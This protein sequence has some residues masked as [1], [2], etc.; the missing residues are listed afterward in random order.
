[1]MF[2]FRY[3][4]LLHKNPMPFAIAKVNEQA[5]SRGKVTKNRRIQNP[6]NFL[7]TRVRTLKYIV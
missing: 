6:E 7:Y 2:F 1:M 5:K 4:Q 3:L